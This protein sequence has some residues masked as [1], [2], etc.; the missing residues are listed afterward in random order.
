MSI[1]IARAASSLIFLCFII[2]NIS[3]YALGDQPVVGKKAAQKYFAEDAERV[4]K[5]SS[6]GGENVLM[7]HIGQYADSQAY[8][9]GPTSPIG[10]GGLANYGVTYLVDQWHGLDTNFRADFSEYSLAGNR[11]VKLSIEPIL[12]FPRAETRFPLY[13]GIGAGGGIFLQQI[14]SKSNISFDYELVMGLRFMELSNLL[15][16]FVE[17]GMKN[18]ILLLSEGQFNGTA[19]TGGLIFTF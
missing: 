1:L 12:T 8:N 14:N 18:H 5:A 15:G 6:S 11:A 10:G 4:S 16:L 2:L 13:F 9:W 19:L 7:L 17:Y 3:S